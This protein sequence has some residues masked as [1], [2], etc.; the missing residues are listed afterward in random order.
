[1]KYISYTEPYNIE[2]VCFMYKKPPPPPQVHDYS[3]MQSDGNSSWGDVVLD[4]FDMAYR[5]EKS[6]IDQIYERQIC[7]DFLY[8]D[9]IIL[10]CYTKMHSDI[11]VA[12]QPNFSLLLSALFL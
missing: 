11:K 9:L 2:S 12:F 6:F 4:S 7:S 1:M 3:V 5:D 10:W 8:D